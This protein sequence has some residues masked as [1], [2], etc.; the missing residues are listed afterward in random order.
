MEILP[1]HKFM[2]KLSPELN[3]IDDHP[4]LVRY[5]RYSAFCMP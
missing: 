3:T 2:F 1:F 5:Y 4:D